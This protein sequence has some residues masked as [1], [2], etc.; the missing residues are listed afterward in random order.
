M[1]LPQ[2][3]NSHLK[4]NNYRKHLRSNRKC[5]SMKETLPKTKKKKT[6]KELL[7][8]E[9]KRKKRKRK[10][11]RK[12]KKKKLQLN[13]TMR[14][15]LNKES[16]RVKTSIL[17][18]KPTKYSDVWEL[19]ISPQ[20]TNSPTISLSATVLIKFKSTRSPESRARS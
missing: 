9:H 5:K 19:G 20:S 11:R 3:W 12:K 15:S 1:I 7:L 16:K 8:M 10:I 6:K 2:Q 18:H 13:R 14:V 4:K 17:K